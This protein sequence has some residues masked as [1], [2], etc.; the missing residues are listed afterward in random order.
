MKYG[1]REQRPLPLCSP[2]LDVS[3]SQLSSCSPLTS[4]GQFCFQPVPPLLRRLTHGNLGFALEIRSYIS[5][6][7]LLSSFLSF[8]FQPPCIET[9]F[10]RLA[11]GCGHR[12]GVRKTRRCRWFRRVRCATSP[13]RTAHLSIIRRAGVGRR[14]PVPVRGGER[15]E[16]R[17]YLVL[18][19][20]WRVREQGWR[21]RRGASA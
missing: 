9:T 10:Q 19:R 6:Q 21:D 18:S 3:T 20:S 16:Q 5:L 17:R 8:S 7:R 12:S 14:Q 15:R 11:A 4:P 13:V 1:D 2:H